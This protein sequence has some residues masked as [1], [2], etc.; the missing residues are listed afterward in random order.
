LILDVHVSVYT[1]SITI[2]FS[3]YLSAP[4]CWLVAGS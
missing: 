3:L 1:Y 4:G 2:A